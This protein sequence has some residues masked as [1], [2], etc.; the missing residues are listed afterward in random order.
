MAIKHNHIFFYAVPVE[1]EHSS[2]C[3]TLV[4]QVLYIF[5]KN[6]RIFS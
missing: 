2:I 1:T 5:L 6:K 4:Q 3:K